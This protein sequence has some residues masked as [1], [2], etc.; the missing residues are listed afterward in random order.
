MDLYDT[1]KACLDPVTA[2]AFFELIRAVDN[3]RPEVFNYF[4]H[5]ITNAFTESL[6][7]LVR[8]ANRMGRGYSFEAIRAKMLFG[9][10]RKTERYKAPVGIEWR[11]CSGLYDYRDLGVP[12]AQIIELLSGGHLSTLKSE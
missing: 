8:V 4:E 3:W 6:N 1:W 12:L 2:A 9:M 11:L 5:R 10:Q 7:G